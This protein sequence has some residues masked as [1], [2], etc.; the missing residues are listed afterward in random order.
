MNEILV[1]TY[2]SG[3]VEFIP[4]DELALDFILTYF[5]MIAEVIVVQKAE[6]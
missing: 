1:I 5:E 3:N 2:K 6:V 4:K